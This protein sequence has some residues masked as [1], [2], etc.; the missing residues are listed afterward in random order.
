MLTEIYQNLK[1]RGLCRSQSAFCRDWLHMSRPYLAVMGNSASI[2]VMY[3][4]AVKLSDR[5][6]HDLAGQLH[7]H[8][9]VKA[10][11]P[12]RS[13]RRTALPEQVRA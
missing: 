13:V 1:A 4:L 9:A 6:Q 5:G 8:I 7:E 10:R 11:A 12:M 3:R 2:D